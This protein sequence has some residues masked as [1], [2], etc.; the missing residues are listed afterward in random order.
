MLNPPNPVQ[1][2]R[3]HRNL[4]R[5]S[6]ATTC[7][8]YDVVRSAI[9]VLHSCLT[10]DVYRRRVP[11]P[12]VG[13]E[14]QT[15]LRFCQRQLFRF[16]RRV[17]RHGQV[18]RQGQLGGVSRG[19]VRPGNDGQKRLTRACPRADCACRNWFRLCST[20][21]PHTTSWTRSST[22]SP[23]FSARCTRESSTRSFDCLPC[24]SNCPKTIS[25]R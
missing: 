23:P 3:E 6:E 21:G 4:G 18:W 13:R 2:R 22:R 14:A 17:P 7:D 12:P 24:C 19:S 5:R 9:P 1:D 20:N 10:A 25:P 16:P 15:P 8:R 11:R